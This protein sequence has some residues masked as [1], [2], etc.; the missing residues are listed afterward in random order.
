MNKLPAPAQFG[1][2]VISRFVDNQG[3]LLASALAYHILLSII[4]FAL[5]VIIGLSHL[6][7]VEQLSVYLHEIMSG[8]GA[9]AA[10]FIVEQTQAAYEKREA[11]GFT[12]LIGLTIFFVAAFRSVRGALNQMFSGLADYEEPVLWMRILLPYV[13]AIVLAAGIVV[14]TLFAGLLDATVPEQWIVLGYTLPLGT[15]GEVMLRIMIIMAQVIL[16]A[17]VYKVFPHVYIK[18]KHAFIGGLVATLL[19]ELARRIVVWFSSTLSV[20]N[21]LY[22]G[23]AVLITMLIALEAAAM[24][25]LLG[26]QTIAVYNDSEKP[27]KDG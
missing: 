15:I 21:L 16:F 8:F 13:Y 9:A 5:L 17:L 3:M 22:G 14:I 26:A 1:I 23:F 20:A 27:E 2:Q 6:M 10:G 24:I 19:W 11:L 12:S 7:P 4:P 25:L 18:W